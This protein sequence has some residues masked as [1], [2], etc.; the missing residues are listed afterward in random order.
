MLRSL[1]ASII[2]TEQP[3]ETATVAHHAD[4]SIA[5]DAPS[6]PMRAVRIPRD[7]GPCTMVVVSRRGSLFFSPALKNELMGV[8]LLRSRDGGRSFALI[9]TPRAY[10]TAPAGYRLRI[11][12]LLPS[13]L[14]KL[15][16]ELPSGVTFHPYLHHDAS[17]G[18]LF[19]SLTMK[20]AH[21]DG[22]GAVIAW[23]DDDGDSWSHSA[24]GQS[25]WDWGKVFT[26]PATC[27]LTRSEL[28]RSGYPSVVYYTATG[29]TLIVGPNQLNYRS[30]DGGKSWE[31]MADSF[32]RE[33]TRALA[34]GYPQSGVVDTRG[35][36][37]RAWAGTSLHFIPLLDKSNIDVNVL[38]SF[39]E[40]E[41][42]SNITLPNTYSSPLEPTIAIDSQDT[43]YLAWGNRRTG[44]LCL[45][46]SRDRAASWSTPIELSPPGVSWVC[47]VTIAVRAPGEIAL[48]YWGSAQREAS[49]DGWVLPDGR[50]YNGYLTVCRDLF[51][52]HPVFASASV[53]ANSAPLLPRGESA[54]TSGEYLGAP[55]FAADGSVWAAFPCLRKPHSALLGQLSFAR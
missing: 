11:K 51:A 3:F 43:L 38:R 31:R 2:F 1:T 24:V 18:R 6:Y 12:S 19:A 28:A 29:P 27:D 26:G 35:G 36:I 40:G 47:K 49:G 55:A 13:G 41:S 17:S 52:G 16:G 15:S 46:F 44:R 22:S 9:E 45:S 39:D 23:S 10:R 30:T 37:Y 7:A 33:R 21:A 20:G 8:D 25:S 54:T 53:N 14:R 4:G 48:A 34:A 32:T 50:P 42:W 5:S